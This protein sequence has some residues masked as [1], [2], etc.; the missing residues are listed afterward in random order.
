MN[1]MTLDEIYEMLKEEDIRYE[2]WR[3]CNPCCA[4]CKHYY[5]EYGMELCK[6][7]G[8]P[9]EEVTDVYCGKCEHWK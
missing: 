2:K 4:N 7:H 3:R 9:P 8:C 1:G 5:E 6:E